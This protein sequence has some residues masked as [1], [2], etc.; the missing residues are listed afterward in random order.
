MFYLSINSNLFVPILFFVISILEEHSSF[1]FS[2]KSINT[3]PSLSITI[4]Y[5]GFCAA[6]LNFDGE[7]LCDGLVLHKTA[8]SKD[9]A[10]A[11]RDNYAEAKKQKQVIG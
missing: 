11:S 8:L 9:D 5:P 4:Q 1:L 2:F 7:W 6:L 3:S 10:R